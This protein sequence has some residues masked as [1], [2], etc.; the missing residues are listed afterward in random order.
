[1]WPGRRHRL[2][3]TDA[4]TRHQHH[5][6]HLQGDARRRRPRHGEQHRSRPIRQPVPSLTKVATE[7]NGDPLPAENV[8]AA[9]QTVLYTLTASNEAGRPPLHDTWLVDCVPVGLESVAIVAPQTG[10]L[11][12]PGN[13][14]TN[15]CE[16]TETY[17]QFN[18]G[19]LAGGSR[20]PGGAPRSCRPRRS[21]ARC[22]RT[23]P[24]SPAA[25]STTASPRRRRRTIPTS[26]S[27]T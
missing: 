15:G 23:R 7:P 3:H 5:E 18:V 8:V 17:V 13:P 16:T 11:S 22:I 14:A 27:T 25:R 9:G 26:V 24:P 6:L 10:D 12:E 1:M 2:G 20:R 21:V 19:S 4:P